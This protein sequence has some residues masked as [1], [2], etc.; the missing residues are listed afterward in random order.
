MKEALVA[1]ACSHECMRLKGNSGGCCT[2]SDRDYI[3]GP[4]LEKD[5]RLLAQTL[6]LSFD[7][8]FI[9]Y[10]EG[11]KMFPNKSHWQN[12]KNFPAL[13]VLDTAEYPCKFYA[14]DKREC[15]IHS[16]RPTMCRD[17]YCDYLKKRIAE[18]G[19]T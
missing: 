13:R 17:F 12:P 4:L 18:D 8:A 5:A 15:K 10:A 19:H 14:Q 16:V 2:V 1:D 7:D 11:S 3:M 6:G 9:S